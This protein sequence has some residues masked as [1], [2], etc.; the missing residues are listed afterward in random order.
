MPCRYCQLEIPRARM[1]T[2]IRARP[3]IRGAPGL[4][5]RIPGL[6]VW[7]KRWKNCTMVK[8]KLISETAVRIQAMKVRSSASRVFS[9]AKWLPAVA[10][11]EKRSSE[12]AVKKDRPRYRREAR[13]QRTVGLAEN[14]QPGWT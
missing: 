4:K 7:A 12:E 1:P 9:Q 5:G 14:F 2:P 8:P 3:R 10:W 6:S 11:V 13:R